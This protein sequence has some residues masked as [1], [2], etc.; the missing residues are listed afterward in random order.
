M[1]SLLGVG[2]FTYL[3]LMECISVSDGVIS[4]EPYQCYGT[5]CN[6]GEELEFCQSY[7]PYCRA[8]ADVL[9]DCQT[10]RSHRNCSRFCDDYLVKQALEKDSK[11]DCLEIPVLQ[12]GTFDTRGPHKHGDVVVATCDPGFTLLGHNTLTCGKHGQWDNTPPTCKAAS[13]PCPPNLMN[14]QW[15][16]EQENGCLMEGV[17]ATTHAEFVCNAGFQTVGGSS[18]RCSF[19]G[20]WIS[21]K[22]GSDHT[23]PFCLETASSFPLTYAVVILSVICVCLIIKQI[24]D[25][26]RAKQTSKECP[27]VESQIKEP[28]LEREKEQVHE[29]Q[30]VEESET[31]HSVSQDAADQPKDSTSRNEN[32]DEN[33]ENTEHIPKRND[34]PASQRS[35]NVVTHFTFNIEGKGEKEDKTEDKTEADDTSSNEPNDTSSNEPVDTLSKELE[36]S[37]SYRPA[38]VCSRPIQETG[39][40]ETKPKDKLM[41]LSNAIVA[42][43]PRDQVT[44]SAPSESPVCLV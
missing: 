10:T 16:I 37:S 3:A 20:T 22:T 25:C 44:P 5:V 12:N 36:D 11:K 33:V 40:V 23:F 32:N 17:Y 24:V 18:W 19:N 29:I 28:L 42:D 27:D 35:V 21:D 39:E 9:D 8:C 34:S 26:V 30:E 41:Q 2:V 1:W 31:R 43:I 14:G 38:D 13:C 6:R 4:L 15:Q 7:F